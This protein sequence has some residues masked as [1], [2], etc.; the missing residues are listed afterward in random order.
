MKVLIADDDKQLCQLFN[1]VLRKLGWEVVLAF[2]AAQAL[3][4]A[5]NTKPDIIVLDINMPGGTGIGV[6]EKLGMNMKTS[7]IPVLVLSGSVDINMEAKTSRLGAVGYMRKPVD[8]EE[9]HKRL[10]SIIK[11]EHA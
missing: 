6:L 1:A 8:V 4:M 9:L 2:D 5:K 10:E 7:M 3:V 11:G